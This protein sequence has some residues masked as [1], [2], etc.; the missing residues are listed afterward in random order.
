M[1][2]QHPPLSRTL[3]LEHRSLVPHYPTFVVV[4]FLGARIDMDSVGVSPGAGSTAPAENESTSWLIVSV[5]MDECVSWSRFHH[6]GKGRSISPG[7]PE[8][9]EKDI[10]TLSL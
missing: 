10:K 2:Q 4:C 1:F 5:F 9:P 7:T 3:G 6:H 8:D